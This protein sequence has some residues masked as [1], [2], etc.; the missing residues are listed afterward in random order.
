M[1][2]RIIV[3]LALSLNCT[4]FAQKQILPDFVYK[5]MEWKPIKYGIM[6]NRWVYWHSLGGML[7]A[8]TVNSQ[9]MMGWIRLKPVKPEYTVAAVL[10]IAT[11][12]EALEYAVEGTEPYCS[13]EI[14]FWDS[15][16]DV[17]VA[18]LGAMIAVRWNIPWLIKDSTENTENESKIRLF[19]YK[20]TVGYG[21]NLSWDL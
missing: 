17:A 3:I 11:V 1:L 5:T 6:E 18:T 14:W 9:T 13:K 12:F 16:G 8:R 21:I 19:P 15:T 7:M 10:G 4:I 20:A 2:I